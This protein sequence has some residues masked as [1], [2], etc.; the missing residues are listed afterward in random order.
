MW[1][2]GEHPTHAQVKRHPWWYDKVNKSELSGGDEIS[3]WDD[4]NVGQLEYVFQ[5]PQDGEYEFWVRANPTGKLSYQINS[6]AWTTIDW[7]KRQDEINLAEDG[8]LDLRFI[9]WVR[10]DQV[11]LSKGEN[12]VRFRMESENNHHGIL[13]CF[14]FSTEPFQPRGALKPGET[15]KAAAESGWFA[16]SPGADSFA[17]SAIDLR[18]LNEKQAGDGGFIGVKDGQFVHGKTGEPVRFWAIN[19]PPDKMDDPAE[20]RKCARILAKRGV[21]LLRIFGGVYDNSGNI[22]SDKVQ[23]AIDVVEAMQTEGIYSDFTIFWSSAFHP[24]AGLDWAAGYDGKKSSVAALYFNPEFQKRYFTWWQ[25]LLTTPGKRSGKRLI[26]NP[27]VASLEFCNEDS[28][29]FWTFDSNNIPDAE[30]RII[31]TQYGQWLKTKYGSLDAALKHW[32]GQHA[33]RDNIAEGRM[34]FRPMWNLMRDRTPRDQDSMAFLVQTQRGFYKLACDTLRKMGFRGVMTGS[35]WTTANQEYLGPLDKY[36]NTI[37]DYVDRHGYFNCDRKGSNE[38][39][40]IMEGQTYFDRNALTF[41]ADKPGGAK[42][43]NNPVIDIHYDGKPSAISETSIERPSRYRS[44]APLYYACYGA[45]QDSNCIYHFALDSDR[46]SAKPGYFMQPWTLMSPGQMGQFPA[47]ALIY[48]QGLVSVGDELVKLNLKIWDVES[49]KGTPMPQDA[50]F[51]ALRAKDVPSGGELKPGNVIDPL[52]HFAGRTSVNFTADGGPAVLKD[53]S[54]F[55]HRDSQTVTSTNGQL[56]LDYGRGILVINAPAAQGISGNLKGAGRAQ[57]KDLSIESDLELGN[58]IAVSLDGKPLATS[59][60]ILLQVMSE[61]K[62]TGWKTQPAGNGTLRV[63]HIG[64]DPW[65]VKDLSGTVKLKRADAT[66]LK[67]TLL[68]ANGYP[69]KSLGTADQIPLATDSLYYLITK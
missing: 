53:L 1:V 57:L 63:T 43:F 33:K 15:A 49:L 32:N 18:G 68:D 23:H 62:P 59:G 69:I 26:D 6:G 39:W 7:S 21:N 27:A 44:V 54:P 66:Q 38:G 19:G 17:E 28:L 25:A 5:A 46:W 67:V 24:A 12:T 50:S 36:S 40:A 31:E 30:M 61:E 55:V 48:R 52:V 29:F 34:G 37:C 4:K 65:Q 42:D 41:D 20:L 16:L 22:E 2:E 45:L 60:T 51:D 35:G 13:D 9:A 64:H 58:I 56:F 3:N 10:A 47:A 8:K 11:K 14:V